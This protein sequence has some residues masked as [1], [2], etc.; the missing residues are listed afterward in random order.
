[1]IWEGAVFT[2]EVRNKIVGSRHDEA[3][4]PTVALD[5]LN[6][7]LTVAELITMTVEEQVRDLLINRRLDAE[8]ARR[9]LDRQYLTD[10]EAR[11]Q[12]ER[13]AIRYPSA[14]P[15]NVPQL[16]PTEEVRKALDA[17]KKGV[18]LVYVDGYQPDTLD[19]VLTLNPGS[20]VTFLRM[21][22]LVGG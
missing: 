15:V 10:E 16:D 12:A 3:Q 21:T 6:E 7:K 22:P 9:A 2:I 14:K 20:K 11:Q 17:F 13:G 8:N 1:M 4:L 5:L 19:D 18:Y